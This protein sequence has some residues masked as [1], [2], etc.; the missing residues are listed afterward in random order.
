MRAILYTGAGGPEVISLTDVEVPIVAAGHVLVRVRAVGLNRA[1]VIQRKGGYPAPPGWPANIPGLEY[2]GVVE[3]LGGGVTSVRVGDRVMGLV[4]GGA[5]AEFVAPHERE[6]IPVPAGLDDEQAAAVPEAFL[7]AYDALVVRGRAAP[8]E[9]VLVHAV[10]SGVST[11]AVQLAKWLGCTVV[12][13]SRT[14]AKLDR[15]R[16]LGMDAGIDTGGGGFREAVGEPVNVILDYFGG[17]ALA[18]NLAVLAPRGRLVLL[19]TLQGGVAQSV[20]VGRILRGRLEV[21]GTVMRARPHEERVP[22]VEEFIQRVM[23]ELKGGRVRPVIG[24]SFPMT[25]MAAAH[26]AMEANQVFGKIVLTW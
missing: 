6:I 11:A 19:G 9:R 26:A 16:G 21:V 22:L 20:D 2:A 8:G 14:A 1:D 15:A 23:P 3:S 24:A 17:P 25:G 5:H 10:G 18:D 4:G 12:G 13:T 7:T